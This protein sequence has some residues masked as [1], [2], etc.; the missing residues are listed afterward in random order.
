MDSREQR[1]YTTLSLQ[2]AIDREIFLERRSGRV[3]LKK[4]KRTPK[5]TT[6]TKSYRHETRQNIRW[7]IIPRVVA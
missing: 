4:L 6:K 2:T 5:A 3:F 7:P 1:D